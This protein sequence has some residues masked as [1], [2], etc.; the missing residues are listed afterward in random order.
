VAH[1]AEIDSNNI[2]I[3]V[4]VVP[5]EVESNG[6][7]YLSNE[8]G[9]GGTW[10]QTSY[11]SRIKKNFAGIGY[12]YDETRDAFIAPKSYPSWVLNEDTCKWEA[13]VAMPIDDNFYVWNEETTSWD[14]LDIPTE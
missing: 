11:N 10:I 7:D 2:V 12:S 5:D 9:L 8:I 3:R 4:L 14:E 13:P 6:Q 1:F